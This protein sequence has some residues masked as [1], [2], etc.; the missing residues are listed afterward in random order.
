MTNSDQGIRPYISIQDTME[1]LVDQV[2]RSMPYAAE[3]CPR[4]SNPKALFNWLKMRV[5]YKN[6][7]TGI[8][9]L[10]RMETMFENNEFGKMGEGDCDCFTITT[11]ACMA[12][13]GWPNKEIILAGNWWKMPSHI[14]SGIIWDD[15]QLI[16]DLTNPFFNHERRYKYRQ[17]IPV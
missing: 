12:V 2:I 16:L 10:Q 17:V 8:E 3:V 11:L 7:P 13:Q 4:F 6:D 14:Y 15:R 1:H 9:L 5:H